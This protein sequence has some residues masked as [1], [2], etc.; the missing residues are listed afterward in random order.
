MRSWYRI[1]MTHEG[2]DIDHWQLIQITGLIVADD[3]AARRMGVIFTVWGRRINIEHD[4]RQ[5]YSQ[6]SFY[7]MWHQSTEYRPASCAIL[8]SCDN[9][10]TGK[11]D[12]REVP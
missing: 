5:T 3:K 2:S 9:K 12:K 4:I 6:S 11:K 10:A 8:E 7:R 1:M